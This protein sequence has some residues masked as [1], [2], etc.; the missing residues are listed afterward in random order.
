MGNPTAAA[1]GV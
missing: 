1:M